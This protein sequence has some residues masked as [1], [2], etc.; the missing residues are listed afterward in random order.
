MLKSK[1]E[2]FLS[3]IENKNI[4]ILTHDLVDIDGFVSS[5]TLKFFLNQIFENQEISIYF[6]ELS[7]PTKDFIKRF[8]KK[9]PD[10]Y[11][12]YDKTFNV[13]KCDLLL[14]VDTNN[15]NQV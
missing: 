3:F 12:T 10:F 8:S 5:F 9:F 6:S 14:I 2:N 1:F 15:L 4:T 11:F 13:S 7:K